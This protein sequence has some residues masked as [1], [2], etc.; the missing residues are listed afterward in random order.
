MDFSSCFLNTISIF[1]IPL[2]S[3]FAAA[4][5]GTVSITQFPAFS[6]QRYCVQECIYSGRTNGAPPL[7][8]SL[9]CNQ[10]YSDSCMCRTDLASSASS[11]LADCINSACS[12]SPP[13][14][15]SAQSLYS[16][17]CASSLPLVSAIPTLSIESQEAFSSLRGCVQDCI[18]SGPSDGSGALPRALQCWGTPAYDGCVCRSD[19]VSTANSFLTICASKYCSG[20]TDDIASAVSAYTAY[21]DGAMNKAAVTAATGGGAAASTAASTGA[22]NTGTSVKATGSASS[23]PTSSSTG[24]PSSGKGGLST[25]AIVGIVVGPLCSILVAGATIYMRCIRHKK[26]MEV[27]ETQ[28]PSGIKAWR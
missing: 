3:H 12:D 10:P 18:Y 19:M 7:P 25:G 22:R 1:L 14:I 23:S 21:C 13:D 26:K 9:S 2:F 16:A 8:W 28:S 24:A 4:S 5:G 15:T 11:M 20:N 6:T 27:L 17:Y